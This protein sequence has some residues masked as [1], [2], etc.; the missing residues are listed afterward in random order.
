M[1]LTRTIGFYSLDIVQNSDSSQVLDPS[2]LKE[3]LS[4]IINLDKPDRRFDTGR[5]TYYFLDTLENIPEREDIQRLVFKLAE[6]GTRPPLIDRNTLDERDNP[7]ELMEGERGK[8]H[9]V[10]RYFDDEIIVLL[11]SVKPGVTIERMEYYFNDYAAR[12]H[13]SLGTPKDYAIRSGI[14]TKDNFLQELRQLR[15]VSIGNIFIEK[16]WLGSEYLNISDRLEEVNEQIIVDIKAQRNSS[17]EVL[18]EDAFAK[19]TS[20]DRQIR[21]IRVYG[22]NQHDKK[23]T[24]DTKIIKKIEHLDFEPEVLTGEIRTEEIL[25]RLVQMIREF[26]L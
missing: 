3:I 6:Y 23:V 16:Q 10:I 14:I 18:I 26:D 17:L 2:R 1:P 21:R 19:F 25:T 7:R 11:E 22:L 4:Y 9:A 13:D 24:I 20:S 12:L 8:I 15:R 5:N